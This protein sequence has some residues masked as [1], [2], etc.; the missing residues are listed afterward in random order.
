[1]NIVYI[2]QS[3]VMHDMDAFMREFAIQQAQ[4]DESAETDETEDYR[5]QNIRR[6]KQALSKI[7][8][9]LG[10]YLK[11]TKALNATNDGRVQDEEIE[12]DLQFP[13][14]WTGRVEELSES[15]H[16]YIVHFMRYDFVKN[17]KYASLERSLNIFMKSFPPSSSPIETDDN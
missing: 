6:F 5:P 1:M 2:Y 3:E 12:L 15:I 9:F 7:Y 17:G 14:S 16:D 10:P 11:N 4:R 13:S 8:R